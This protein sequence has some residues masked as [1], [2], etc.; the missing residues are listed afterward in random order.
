[1][2]P[3]EPYPATFRMSVDRPGIEPGFP[4]RQGGVFPLDHQPVVFQ[5]TAGES[6]PSHRPCK[7]QSPP[8]ACRPSLLSRGPSGNRTRSPSLPRTCA[9]GTPT[10]HFS[11]DPGWNRTSTLLHVTQA[12][13][14]LDHGIVSVTEVGV[15]PTKSPRSRPDRFA[16][17]R[18]RS[19]KWRVR[20]SHPAVQAYEARM[21]TGPPASSCRSR[22][23]AGPPA[24]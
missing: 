13:S 1:V 22:Y 3:G 9:A 14:P 21:S 17:L 5:W 23:R 20:G 19:V 12:S 11:S 24:L 4:P 7:G 16:C 10:D 15:E 8:T 2:R 6:N 18:T